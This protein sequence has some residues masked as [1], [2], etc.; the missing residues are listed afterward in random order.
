MRR[1]VGVVAFL[2]ACA[3]WAGQ[4]AA[5]GHLVLVGGGDKPPEAMRKFVELAGGPEAPIAVI[6]TA[7]EEAD[8]GEYYVELFG[9]KHGCRKVTVLPIKT[10][11]DAMSAELAELAAGAKGIFFAGGDQN[12]VTRA[13]LDTP[14]GAAIAAA[15]RAGA[16]VGGTSAGT[17]CQSA[18]MIT[19]EGD[20]KA[21]RAGAV[22][23]ARGL[24][25][26]PGVIVDQHFVARQRSNRLLSAILEHPD[27]L[28]VGVDE[29][30][31]IWVRPG[32]DFTVLGER[33]VVVLDAAGAEVRRGKGETGKELLGVSGLRTHVLLPGD[34]FD[35]TRRALVARAREARAPS[36]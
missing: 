5:R 14:V 32:G 2:I 16:V 17:A 3:A 20:F 8:T 13:L 10:R 33:S 30:T 15:F 21:I 26:F 29:D 34:E 1:W 11:E 18:L 31:A 12:R 24:G 4:P 25:F 35:V 6:P 27:L 36:Q 19:G 28:G 9:K 7:S 22:E 23:L